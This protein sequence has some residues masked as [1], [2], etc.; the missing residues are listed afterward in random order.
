ML[1]LRLVT[2]QTTWFL[3]V[4][5]LMAGV[6]LGRIVGVVRDGLDKAVIPPLVIELVIGSVLLAAHLSA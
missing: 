3:A 5:I 2:G 4:A 1:V 6:I